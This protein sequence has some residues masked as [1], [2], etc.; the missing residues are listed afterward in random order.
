[1]HKSRETKSEDMCLERFSLRSLVRKFQISAEFVDFTSQK[2]IKMHFVDEASN[3]S[4]VLISSMIL[5]LKLICSTQK[6]SF[7]RTSILKRSKYAG[8]SMIKILLYFYS[9]TSSVSLRNNGS[10]SSNS[11]KS[12]AASELYYR[13]FLLSQNAA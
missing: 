6:I 12:D 4:K 10:Y 1:M 5:N 11:N 7:A 3:I 2:I 9:P 13:L 8:C